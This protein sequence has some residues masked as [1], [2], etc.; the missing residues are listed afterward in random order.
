MNVFRERMPVVRTRE[1][2]QGV[3][4]RKHILSV[5]TPA[6]WRSALALLRQSGAL[7]NMST[8]PLVVR[9]KGHTPG[10]RTREYIKHIK[11]YNIYKIY[12]VYIKS[13][14]TKLTKIT[15]K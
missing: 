3:R 2:I 8:A 11:I 4:N 14:I 15:K 12:K 5:R 7:R 1:Y 9:N 13:Q 10:V 6:T